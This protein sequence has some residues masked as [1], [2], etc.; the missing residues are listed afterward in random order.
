MRRRLL[1]A[2][3]VFLL[4][5]ATAGAAAAPPAA[6]SRSA[7]PAIGS[8][9]AADPPGLTCENPS[10]ATGFI[11][12]C[13][14]LHPGDPVS[15]GEGFRCT[16]NF[17]WRGSDGHRYMGTAGHCAVQT[18]IG[19]RIESGTGQLIGRLVYRVWD[20]GRTDEDDFALIRLDPSVKAS[21]QMQH[22]GG[23]TAAYRDLTDQPRT[24]L[25]AGQAI[26]V[27]YIAPARELLATGVTHPKMI[28]FMGPASFNDSGAPV[29]TRDGLAAG[30]VVALADG[31]VPLSTSASGGGEAGASLISRI[32]P[33]VQ[34]AER[35]LRT[36]L[37]LQTAPLR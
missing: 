36:R 3:A 9:Q 31:R 32:D 2:F 14:V 33:A 18:S 15:L 21:P 6:P 5:A 28:R 13:P 37:T 16:L 27:S 11:R 4:G 1:Y 25:M 8:N 35:A 22:W 29:I 20:G 7:A 24:L 30:W 10:G 34:A 17:L 19:G 23:P 12:E 26:G